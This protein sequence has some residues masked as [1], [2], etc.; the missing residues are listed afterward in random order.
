MRKLA[1]KLH[2]KNDP[3]RK[4]IIIYRLQKSSTRS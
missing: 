2:M 3:L 4:G 1:G